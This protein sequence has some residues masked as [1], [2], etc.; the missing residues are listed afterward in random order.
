MERKDVPTQAQ[1]PPLRG[2]RGE[3]NCMDGCIYQSPAECDIDGKVYCSCLDTC[4]HPEN[5]NGC[6]DFKCYDQE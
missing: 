2:Q 3:L 6:P 4:C 5:R 1:D